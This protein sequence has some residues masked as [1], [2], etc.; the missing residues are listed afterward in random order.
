MGVVF[1][2]I[3]FY[4]LAKYRG[5][6]EAVR[7]L[8]AAGILEQLRSVDS[9]LLDLGDVDCPS[10]KSDTGPRNIHNMEQ[11][12]DGTNK[13]KVKLSRGVDASKLIFL[14]G[15]ECAFVVGSLAA[16]KTVHKGRPGMVW[17][18]AHGDFNTP[19]TTPSGFIGGM[20]LALACGRGPKLSPE[21]EAS[22]PLLN[23]KQVVH[24]GSRSLD[25]GEKDALLSGVKVFTA[26]DVEE[27]GARAVAHETAHRLMGSCD[28]I[29][30]HLDVD[31]LDPSVM[32]AV[33]FPEP[34][35]LTGD[36]VLSV[37]TALH[38]TGKLKAI[39]LTA[40]NPSKDVENT[41]RSFLLSLAPKLVSS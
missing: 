21:I 2:G 39:D 25:P 3:P 19:E 38:R 41:G 5:M 35:G 16:L 23:E 34:G 10:I 4:T 8:R 31:V 12:L 7:T 15:G 20:P 24:I 32:P 29:V 18:D 33:N 13:V 1:A 40:Y 22:R 6:A 30:A 37:F 17:I 28:W 9:H 36:D 27:K 26:K 11:F 14:L